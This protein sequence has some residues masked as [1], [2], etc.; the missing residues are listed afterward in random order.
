MELSILQI[1]F[2]T[3]IAYLKMTDTVNNTAVCIQYDYLRLAHRSGC[4]R[5]DNRVEHRSYH[6]ADV[7][8]GRGS[9][10]ILHAGLSDCGHHATTIAVTTGKGMEAGLAIGLPVAML[11]VNFD[12]IYKIFNGFLMRKETS[13]I[14]EGKF[15]SALNMIK[16]SP[17]FYGLCSAVPVLVCIVAGPTVVNA[18]LDFMPAWFTTGLTIAGGVL[19]GVGMAMLLM[20]MPLGK[21]WSFLL[22]GFVLAAYLKVPVL[23]IAAIGLAGAYEIY[24]NQMKAGTAAAG[25]VAGGLEDE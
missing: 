12:V 6:A 14:E 8:G 5:S 16:I 25:A 1:V 21:Y 17:V 24:K 18:I 19:P 9:R 10:R 11:G 3:L 15:Q 13:L 2:I 22:V 7:Y 23:G 4:G 20:Y